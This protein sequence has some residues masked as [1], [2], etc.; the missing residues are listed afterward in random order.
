MKINKII[1]PKRFTRF[2]IIP[3]AIF[4]HKKISAASTGLYC[5]LFSHDDKQEMTFQFILNH[6][7][8]GRD[9]LQ[10]CI[11]ELTVTGFLIRD[12]I[13]IKGKFKG[14]NYILNDK[15]LTEKPLTGKPLTGKQQQSNITSN[16]IYNKSNIKPNAKIYD[17]IVT[18]AFDYFV[19]LFPIKNRPTTKTN[20]D[21][22]LDTL[23]KIH[24]IDKYDLR[25][26]YLKCKELRNNSFWETNF[27][28]LVKLRNYNREGIRYIDYFMYKPKPNVNEIRKKIPGAIKF[29]KYNDPT[30][31]ELVGVKTING[32]IDYDM[33]KTILSKSDLKILLND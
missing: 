31:K 11:K 5:W 6:F 14:Y 18:D 10:N 3:S 7:S 25:Q 27:L 1:K 33:L 21:R 30:G 16:I 26:V 2:V 24:R 17:K 13:K 32:D 9:A 22:W 28:S 20:I 29:Y 19:E 12:Q 8:N 23:D 15:P 4:R